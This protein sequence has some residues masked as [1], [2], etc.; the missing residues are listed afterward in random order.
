MTR[1]WITRTTAPLALLMLG[2]VAAAAADAGQQTSQA[3]LR[4]PIAGTVDGGGTF[5]G[6][7][8]ISQF[9][10]RDGKPFAIGMISGSV[11][12]ATGAPAGT[13]LVG[14][15]A[16][17]VKVG[18]GSQ[19]ASV[20]AAAVQ[21]QQTCDV[22]HLELVP[23]TFDVLGLQ[24]TTSPITIDITADA[25]GTNVIGHLICTILETVTN[26]LRLVDLLNLLLA[27][28]TGLVGFIPL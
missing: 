3:V 19:G 22:L 23:I 28:L 7:L 20:S 24:V 27:L 1:Q 10:A 2:A 21:Q 12:A 6:T 16:F 4:V 13:V 14:P 9:V 17:E 11:T 5:S 18:P 26:V 25:S 15:K 8:S